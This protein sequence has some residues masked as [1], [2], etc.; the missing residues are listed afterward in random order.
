MLE[1]ESPSL[2]EGVY[3]HL[4]KRRVDFSVKLDL[5]KPLEIRFNRF[6]YCQTS[7]YR[8]THIVRSVIIFYF[9]R[10]HAMKN[11]FLRRN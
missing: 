11:R 1:K 8:F 2:V 6:Y 4:Q 3:I 5:T 10:F 9:D 7:R